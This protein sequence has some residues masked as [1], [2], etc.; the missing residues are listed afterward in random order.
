M[1]ICICIYFFYNINPYDL[2]NMEYTS[3]Q[4]INIYILTYMARYETSKRIFE[5]KKLVY[6]VLAIDYQASLIEK[7]IDE[8]TAILEEKNILSN[9]AT[10]NDK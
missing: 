5:R 3:Q 1:Y 2:E 6:S 7:E 9:L 10:F 4:D 8:I